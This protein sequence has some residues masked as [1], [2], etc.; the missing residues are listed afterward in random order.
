MKRRTQIRSKG[1]DEARQHLPAILADA[2]AGRA[3]IITRRGREIAAVVPIG[4]A[5]LPKPV[6]L[7]GL[8]GTGRGLWGRRSAQTLARLRDEWG[9]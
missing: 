5:R 8:A 7:T 2:A 4:T 3:T 9:R 6:P 1:T